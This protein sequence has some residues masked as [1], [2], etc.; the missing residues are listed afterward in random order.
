MRGNDTAKI[1]IN[2]IF[3]A[4]TK[5]T[6]RWQPVEHIDWG[7]LFKL[8]AKQGVI[9]IAWEGVEQLTREGLLRA[10]Q[11]PERT[12]KLQWALSIENIVKRYRRQEA[13]IGK[14]ATFY[15]SHDIRMMLLK[16]YGISL[17]YPT[18]EHREC[19]DIDIWLYGEQERADRLLREEKD[20]KIDEDVHHHTTFVING[21]LIENHY[22]FINIHAHTSSKHIERELKRLAYEDRGE[23][24]EVGD[25]AVY[26]PSPNLN[27]LFL[28]R[29]AASHFASTE[30]NFRQVID[31][32]LFVK[33]HHAKIDWAWLGS[34]AREMNMHRFLDSLNAISIDHFGLP[35]ECV[36]DF[37]RNAALEE[38]VLGD[39]ISPEFSEKAPKGNILKRLIFK[40]RR[41]WANRWKHR[42]VH[43]E[44]LFH[45]F[46]VQVYSHLL[47]PKTLR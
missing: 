23:V 40:Y 41:W 33:R 19:G 34:Y 4:L 13:L 27:A 17:L 21:I 8:A 12:L 20:I 2:I 16:G 47:K 1:L 29:H 39:I 22:D 45:T 32:A 14:L 28:L 11:L 9:A 31:W 15:N 35:K 5:S 3:V 6:A 25:S 36:P 24:I 18:P 30:L 37:E 43:R 38:R 7:A 26:L 44:G 46:I 10:E 42:L